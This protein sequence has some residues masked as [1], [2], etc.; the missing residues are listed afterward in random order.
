[1]SCF[2]GKIVLNGYTWGLVI[3]SNRYSAEDKK[4]SFCKP[5]SETGGLQYHFVVGSKMEGIIKLLNI[6]KF[7]IKGGDWNNWGDRVFLTGG[8]E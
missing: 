1:M 8:V 3:R 5:T 4:A 6:N 2:Q 7:N